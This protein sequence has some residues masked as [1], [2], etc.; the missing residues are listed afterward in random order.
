VEDLLWIR[1]AGQRQTREGRN[2]RVGWIEALVE[3]Q[4]YYNCILRLR[5]KELRVDPLIGAW[6]RK[7]RMKFWWIGEFDSELLL[8]W[9]ELLD[10]KMSNEHMIKMV[11]VKI[12]NREK[13]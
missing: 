3:V 1:A 4:K 12:G 8:L 7:G 11:Q 10:D 5:R 6:K 9:K 13:M 2:Q